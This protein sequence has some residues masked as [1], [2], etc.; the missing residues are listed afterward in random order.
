[1]ARSLKALLVVAVLALGAYWYWS[2]YLALNSM[3]AAVEARNADDFNLRVDFPRVRESL[4]TQFSSLPAQGRAT[5]GMLLG[6]GFADKMVDVLV[7]PEFVAQAMEKAQPYLQKV[8]GE[9]G[10][11]DGGIK[12]EFERAGLN[13]FIVYGTP[14]NSKDVRIGAVLERSG[15]ATWKLTGLEIPKM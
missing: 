10:G 1:M 6:E 2:P 12:W 4:K 5:A 14:D 15:F 8:A 9:N 13:R 7:R 11:K 3:K